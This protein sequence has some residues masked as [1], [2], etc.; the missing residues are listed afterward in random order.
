MIFTQDIAEKPL[1]YA[2]VEE[3]ETEQKTS[4]SGDNEIN[5]DQIA[6]FIFPQ[7]V[8]PL[9]EK[10]VFLRLW[11]PLKLKL[12]KSTARFTVEG[13]P[14]EMDCEEVAE[15][16]S[17]ISRTFLIY[18]GKADAGS[19]NKSEK[20]QWLEMLENINF[21]KFNIE[22]ASPHYVEGRLIQKS[23]WLVEW[24]DGKRATLP[25]PMAEALKLLNSGDLF[26]V[27]VKWGEDGRPLSLER[28]SILETV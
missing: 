11:E 9:G 26:S 15:L 2:Y 20:K 13:W 6:E 23:P 28:L 5:L 14:I 10:G 16:P 4:Y 18:L 24:M 8:Y 19:L 22:R 12:D 27:Y 17:R 7:K 21:K 3:I 1:D 25:S